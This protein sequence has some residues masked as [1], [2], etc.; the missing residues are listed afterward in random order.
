[1][2][3]VDPMTRGVSWTAKNPNRLW[4]QGKGDK[5]KERYVPFLGRL[6]C[7]F[8]MLRCLLLGRLARLRELELPAESQLVLLFEE[9]QELILEGYPISI[10]RAVIHSLPLH[11][12]RLLS[13]RRAIRVLDNKRSVRRQTNA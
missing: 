12:C 6:Q 9:I 11:T 5:K 10:L 13:L 7:P 4:V 3:S 2:F 8:G 1:M